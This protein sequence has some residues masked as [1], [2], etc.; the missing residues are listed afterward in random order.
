MKRIL[1]LALIS[2]FALAAC[3]KELAPEVEK[4][5]NSEPKEEALIKLNLDISDKAS[6]EGT[7][8]IKTSW[9]AGDKIYLFFTW[10]MNSYLGGIAVAKSKAAII[11][12]G[13]AWVLDGEDSQKILNR[14]GESMLPAR[15][16]S[17]YALYV[18]GDR[19][20]SEIEHSSPTAFSFGAATDYN[21]TY[22]EIQEAPSTAFTLEDGYITATLQFSQVC[23][24]VVVSNIDPNYNWRLESPL[25]SEAGYTHFR[26]IEEL[27]V[28]DYNSKEFILFDGNTAFGLPNE[29]GEAFYLA[30]IND[31]SDPVLVRIN[32]DSIHRSYFKEFPAGRSFELAKAY[33]LIGPELDAYGDIIKP[34]GW[35]NV[36][37]S[38][39]IRYTKTSPEAEFDLNLTSSYL[40]TFGANSTDGLSYYS[41]PNYGLIVFDGPVT[42]IGASVCKNQTA[43]TGI[44]LPST[45]TVIADDAFRDCT[46][47]RAIEIPGGVLSIGKNAFYDCSYLRNVILHEGLKSLGL[48]AFGHCF[49]LESINI[50]SSVESLTN[51]S[52]YD[53][54]K[55][56]NVVLNE[57]L[58]R[59]EQNAFFSCSALT[60]IS[61]PESVTF[62]GDL[63]FHNTNLTSIT[64]PS[65]VKEI[66]DKAFKTRNAGVLQ[67]VYCKAVT[68]PSLGTDVF[69]NKNA[70]AKL[71][72]PTG[73]LAAYE[74]SDWG[75]VFDN[76]VEMDF[77]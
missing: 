57:G 29:D 37:E 5:V 2:F 13:I 25:S 50:P 8:A 6:Y 67:T 14:I 24:Q 60:Q 38:N 51:C 58:K 74:A 61:I 63:S 59:I 16:A 56:S 32:N 73:T 48:F 18:A 45:V 40:E 15:P 65:K 23:T 4:A 41:G 76:I 28:T 62:I 7:K 19:S 70:E 31:A 20:L 39:T 35:S 42:K 22:G 69:S 43:L 55:L 26:G 49:R 36:I 3:R 54:G 44:V 77:E 1:S 12:D 64:I 34:N 66:G 10:R 53:C 27:R 11:Y 46:N 21:N 33:K 30:E 71:Y 72:V 52:F 68:P 75:S 47:L 17:I 9:E